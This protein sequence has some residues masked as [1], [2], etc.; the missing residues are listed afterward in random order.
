[1]SNKPSMPGYYGH[2]REASADEIADAAMR[3]Y[4]HPFHARKVLLAHRLYLSECGMRE[5]TELDAGIET[6][7]Q[8]T[9]GV[10]TVTESSLFHIR[11]YTRKGGV[12]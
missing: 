4:G 2:T 3:V 7:E 12:T 11:A 6:L 9:M 1:M 8:R 10:V 5:P